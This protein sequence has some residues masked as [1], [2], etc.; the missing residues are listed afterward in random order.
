MYILVNLII[1]TRKKRGAKIFNRLCTCMKKSDAYGDSKSLIKNH[2]S[3]SFEDN[4]GLESFNDIHY[5]Q[6]YYMITTMYDYIRRVL[7]MLLN[8]KF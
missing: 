8:N 1:I 3:I 7:V 4:D 6:F 5:D 2:A